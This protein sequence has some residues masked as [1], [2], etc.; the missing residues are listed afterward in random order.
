MPLPADFLPLPGYAVDGEGKLSKTA[1]TSL[2]D[3]LNLPEVW[4]P[5][6]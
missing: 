6:E 5:A 1:G 4:P 2:A 3:V